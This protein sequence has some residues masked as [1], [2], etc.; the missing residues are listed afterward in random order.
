MTRGFLKDFNSRWSI[1]DGANEL[2]ASVLLPGWTAGQT[3]AWTPP[4]DLALKSEHV[5]SATCPIFRKSWYG[6]VSKV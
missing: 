3:K 4:P 1:L 5:L 6:H 2:Y